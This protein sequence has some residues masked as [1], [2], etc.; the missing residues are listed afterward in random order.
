[1]KNDHRIAVTKKMIA[2]TFLE[3]VKTKPASAITVK[4]LC[5]NAHINRA[6]FYA[7]YENIL[8]LADSI[9]QEL[10]GKIIASVSSFTNSDSNADM[11]AVVCRCIADNACLCEIVFGKYADADFTVTVLE[12]FR[13]KYMSLWKEFSDNDETQMNY[14]YTFM[15]NGGLAVLRSWAQKGMKESPEYIAEF[16]LKNVKL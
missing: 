4:E 8:D 3:L 2:Q 6:T 1:M 13:A 11:I 12:L 16:I 10:T 5:E 9:R 14:T 7:H 15:A